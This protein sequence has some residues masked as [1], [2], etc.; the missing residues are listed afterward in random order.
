M[1]PNSRVAAQR[2]LSEIEVEELQNH[3]HFLE[4]LATCAPDGL[5]P[6]SQVLLCDTRVTLDWLLYV[7]H[8]TAYSLS[9]G[10][11]YVVPRQ[12]AVARPGATVMHTC[13]T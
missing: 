7:S 3:L 9:G 4:H 6:L 1:H 5:L 12:A 10:A 2:R 8:S 11:L 13:N